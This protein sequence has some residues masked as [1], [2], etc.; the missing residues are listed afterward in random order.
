MLMSLEGFASFFFLMVSFGFL[1]CFAQ[2]LYI[3]YRLEKIKEK[4]GEPKD[5]LEKIEM[6]RLKDENDFYIYL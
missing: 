2:R 4:K 3:Q 1:A 6:E 5:I